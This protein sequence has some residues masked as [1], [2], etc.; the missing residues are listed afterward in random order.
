MSETRS[1]LWMNPLHYL[2]PNIISDF[3]KAPP[4]KHPVK[5]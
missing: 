5:S 3:A 4:G 2:S 1:G